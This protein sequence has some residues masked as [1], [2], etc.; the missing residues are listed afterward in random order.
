MGG[1]L[2]ILK[3]ADG[4]YYTGSTRDEESPQRRLWE[5]QT[6]VYPD[7]YTRKRRPVE[8]VYSCYF[9]RISEAAAM[10]RRIKGWSRVKK[11]AVIRGD[12]GALPDLS[13]RPSAR[14][15]KG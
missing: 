13:R 8:M 5:H 2:Y 9:E 6:G 14:G 10:E 4:S 7:A 15:T 1:W 3:C 11:E 12:W